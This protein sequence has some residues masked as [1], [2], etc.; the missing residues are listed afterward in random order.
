MAKRRPSTADRF[1]PKVDQAGGP[2]ACWPWTGYVSPVGYG[3]F[4]DSTQRRPTTSHRQ[5]YILATGESIDGVTICHHCDNRVCCN[6]SHLF[7][8][9]HALNMADMAAKGRSTAGERN[10]GAKLSAADVVEIRRLHGEGL[11]QR[12]IAARFGVQRHAVGMILRGERW[13][14][15]VE[16]G[17]S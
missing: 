14:C 2:D 5:A 17:A 7:A 9:T 8:G 4:Y 12:E 13:S 6:P 1:W 15:V 16:G 3:L 10:P 11:L